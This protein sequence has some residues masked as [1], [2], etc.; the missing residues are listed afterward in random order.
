MKTLAAIPSPSQPVQRPELRQAAVALEASFLSEMLKA[1]NME[2]G[3][4]SFGGGVG[5]EQFTSFLTEARAQVFAER[6]G[7]GLAEKL[8][9]SML[10][11]E[12][13]AK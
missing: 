13:G 7:I 10:R 3:A 11:S 9:E 6:G 8:Y 1:A 4:E 5:E 2:G 12:L